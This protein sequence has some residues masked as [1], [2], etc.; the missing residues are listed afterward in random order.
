MR[1]SHAMACAALALAAIWG[2]QAAAADKP[3]IL[4]GY[5][6]IMAAKRMR[7]GPHPAIDFDGRIGDPVIAP[8]PGVVAWTLD[9]A[10]GLGCG[11]GMLISHEGF[12]RYT[13]YC[14]LSAV[15]VK[16][17]EH[18]QR[19]QLI[20]LIGASGEATSRAL[21]CL[22]QCEPVS[23][24][25]FAL[26]RDTRGHPDG[27]L[28]GTY[29]PMSLIVGCFDPKVQYPTDRLVLTYPVPCGKH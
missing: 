19:G 18:V 28:E 7:S 21:N 13:L 17:G 20:G 12:D 6:D 3:K 8:A 27:D 15:R 4:S 26:Q 24:V 9:E 25:H 29:D 5:G 10:K 22:P 11:N 2:S 23:T 14:Q 16:K 1:T